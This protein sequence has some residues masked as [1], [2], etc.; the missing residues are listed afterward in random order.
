MVFFFCSLFCL[1][2]KRYICESLFSYYFFSAAERA[3]VEQFFKDSALSDRPVV[4]PLNVIVIFT[5]R[6]FHSLDIRELESCLRQT[7]NMTFCRM[8]KFSI[9]LS[10]TILYVNKK[11]GS[12]TFIFIHK[13]LF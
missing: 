5:R 9:H 6:M 2:G 4:C 3:Q 10:L 8:T 13:K 7:A 12:F 1:E 11:L